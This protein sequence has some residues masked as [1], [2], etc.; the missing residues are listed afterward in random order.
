MKQRL[1]IILFI[2]FLTFSQIQIGSDIN[3][4]AADDLS[5]K[6]ISLN[7]DGNIVAIGAIGNIGNGGIGTGSGHV[8][9]FENIGGVWTQIGSDID[10]E[11]ANN[12]FGFS[13]SISSDG[14]I[15]A[16]GA[17]QNNGNG[18]T[19]G[20]VRVYENIGGVWTQIGS[21]IDGEAANDQSGRSVSLSSNGSIVAIGAYSNN[22][23]GSNSGHVRVY[24]NIGGV[25]T[26]I[27]SDI[28]GEAANDLSGESVSISSDGSIVAI[29]A[30]GNGGNG[31]YSG[32]VRVYENIGSVWTQIGSDIDGE[33]TNDLSGYSV[34]LSS[35]GSI[36]AI[37]AYGNIGSGVI[38]TGSGHVRIFENIGGVW[39]QIGSDID[40]EAAN[41][42]SGFSVS[43]SS[44]GS[45][46]AIG[47]SGNGGNGI[48]SGHV[49]IYKN[50]GGVWT[51][52]GSDID[53][54]AANDQSG[55]SV[56][57]SSDGSVVAIG[58][59]A[60]KEI[61]T[62]S[63]HVRIYDLSAVLSTES[64]NKDYFTYYPNPAKDILN[65]KLNKGLELQQ[66]NVYNIQSQ[67]LFSTKISEINLSNLT[68][69]MY[70][71][72]VETNDGKSA[73]KIVIE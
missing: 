33:A 2:P 68:S 47:A 6:S 46:V 8:R 30:T 38:G 17:P 37:G 42:R 52:I 53:G 26:Q 25:W 72:E 35:D 36:V 40:G 61:G 18:L 24:E 32:H 20:H 28:D 73:K 7:S 31:N 1:L 65:I 14:S 13:V 50:L 44:D 56:S 19:S 10:G 51:Q 64:F 12:N 55:D 15:V 60:N 5:G 11:A 23:N 54:E 3:G 9:I 62:N 58:A 70:F 71:I 16:I 21:D 48:Y 63:G 45:V 4:E 49:R 66:I 41:D 67:Y 43:L 34:S 22:G 29:G 39:T 57:L 59:F 69:G 27:G